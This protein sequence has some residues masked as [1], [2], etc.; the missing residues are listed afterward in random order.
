MKWHSIEIEEIFKTLNTSPRGLSEEEAE[1]RLLEYGPN[2][3]EEEEPISK[4]RILLAQIKNPIIY[5]IL[6]TAIITFIFGKYTDTIVI[7][8]VILFNTIIGYVQEYKAESSLQALKLMVSPESDVIRD[9]PEDRICIEMRIKAS[10]VVPGDVVL[11]EG[12]DKIPADARI[13]EAI[14]L[15]IDESML[16]GESVSVKKTIKTLD[17]DVIV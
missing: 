1:R 14:N 10:E 3:I 16:T 12:G 17:E 7:G 4:T 13:F 15:E 11:L 2:Q 9:C 8:I 6:I 5:I